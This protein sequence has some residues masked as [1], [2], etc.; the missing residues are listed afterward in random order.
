[1]G[2]PPRYSPKIQSCDITTTTQEKITT[3]DDYGKI[4]P[5]NTQSIENMFNQ[6]INLQEEQKYLDKSKNSDRRQ[7][8]IE[9]SVVCKIEVKVKG[10]NN[11]FICNYCTDHLP[12]F[13]K[14]IGKCIIV[15]GKNSQ[16]ICKQAKYGENTVRNTRD[17][18]SS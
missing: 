17:D 15:N 5:K 12:T 11:C 16:S 7:N 14:H 8:N 1:M 6:K 3:A 4:R 18:I 10:R 2:Q 13:I 9:S